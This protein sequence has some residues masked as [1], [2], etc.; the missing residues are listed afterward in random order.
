MQRFVGDQPCAVDRSF[1]KCRNG[2]ESAERTAG[3][4]NASTMLFRQCGKQRM[5]EQCANAEHDQRPPRSQCGLGYRRQQVRRR[6]LDD[7]I[8][9]Q[10]KFIECG[11]SNRVVQGIEE[12]LG[13][14]AITGSDSGQPHSRYAG[15]QCAGQGFPYRA[16][17]GDGDAHLVMFCCLL[18]SPLPCVDRMKQ[19][20]DGRRLSQTICFVFTHQL[21][22]CITVSAQAHMKRKLPPLLA[23]RAFEAV[24][25]HLS[26]TRAAGELNVT[27][28]AVSRQVRLLEEHLRRTLFTRLTRRIELTA[29]G[30]AYY[31]ATRHAF[32]LV[33][34][35][36]AAASK[37]RPRTTLTIRVL[38]SIGSLWLMPR[39]RSFWQ[40]NRDI[41][42]QLVSSISAADPGSRESGMA[43]G[44][45]RLPGKRYGA[46]A[47][48]IESNWIGKSH[49]I[50]TDLLFPDVLTPVCSRP[51][52]E[53]GPA[54]TH[55]A[56]LQHYRLI[57]TAIRRRAWPDWL[58]SV[59]SDVDPHRNAIEF[60]QYFMSLQAAREGEGI[61]IVPSILA[62]SFD[63]DGELVRPFP[64]ALPSAGEYYLLTP[65]AQ[66][67]EA[68]VRRFR[69]WILEES[70]PYR[71]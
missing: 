57:H 56:G 31:Q 5:R 3:G 32:D 70:A 29:E 24:A 18:H 7:R 35:A 44:V 43:I 62:D 4:E 21:K 45:G 13:P 49:D 71:Q 8:G 27:Q 23:L 63:P 28:A 42:V 30:Q 2:I 68:P 59:G 48:R 53:Q 50:R 20:S 14:A 15:I 51:M 66:Y 19:V 34:E 61:A 22:S 46:G 16:E 40:E 41:D 17:A 52:L 60:G 33:E 55:P 6:A 9:E 25:R 1:G 36:T 10:G 67:D 26:F 58:A 65:R 47:P 12:G 11:R 54:L 64:S 69:H 37:K 39:L 38:P